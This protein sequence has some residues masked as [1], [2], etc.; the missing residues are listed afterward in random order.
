M[1]MASGRHAQQVSGAIVAM[2]GGVRRNALEG[3]GVVKL[4]A[5]GGGRE[6]CTTVKDGWETTTT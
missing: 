1:L 5:V 3:H 6:G 2:A 4:E